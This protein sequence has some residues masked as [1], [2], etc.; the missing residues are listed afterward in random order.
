MARK[1]RLRQHSADEET[2]DTQTTVG[3]DD[4]YDDTE[5]DDAAELIQANIRGYQMNKERLRRK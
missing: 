3:S 5:L 2:T 1:Q 4:G